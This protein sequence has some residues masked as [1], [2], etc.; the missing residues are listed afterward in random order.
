M[1][2]KIEAL[3][4]YVQER[5]LWQ[6]YSRAWDREEN[7]NGVLGTVEVLLS[8]E[9][10]VLDTAQE[11]CFYADAKILAAELKTKFSWLGN[12]EKSEIEP[13]IAG[14]KQRIREIAIEKSTNCELH[15][16]NY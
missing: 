14:V 12:M 4:A 2:D 3:T 6:F 13:L 8:G 10:P 15:V 9:T 7:I 11:K 5:C 1:I 16:P